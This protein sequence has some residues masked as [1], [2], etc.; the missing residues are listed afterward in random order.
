[1]KLLTVVHER[2]AG[3]GVFAGVEAERGAELVEWVPA[4]GAP[5]ALEGHDGALVL[6]GSMHPDQED[7]HPWLGPEKELIGG[8]VER[9]VPLLGVCLG[10]E[11]LAESSGG[12]A[13][14]LDETHIGWAETRLNDVGLA[15]PVLGGLPERFVGFQWHSYACE[16]PPGS[17]VLAG[18]DDRLDAFR[19][20][21]AWGVQFHVEATSEIM[22]GWLESHRED[23]VPAGFDPNALHEEIARRIEASKAVGRALFRS[24]LERVGAPPPRPGRA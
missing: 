15:D 14:W 10:A 22:L 17:A 2:T 9:G 24:F 23:E 3:P 21:D 11:L 19:V 7:E 1:M 13:R 6:G 5:P 8:L 20:R 16:P 4:E 12:R 18:G